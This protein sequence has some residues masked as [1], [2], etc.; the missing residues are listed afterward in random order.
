[1]DI[2]E[3]KKQFRTIN[4]CIENKQ[5][6]EAFKMLNPLLLELH[7]SDLIDEHYNLELTYKNTLKYLSQGIKDPNQYQILNHLTVGIL[8]LS[9][10]TQNQLL[11][12]Y[13]NE[14]GYDLKREMQVR[15]VTPLDEQLHQLVEA[16]NDAQLK[17]MI[18]PAN[19]YPDDFEKLTSRMFQYLWLSDVFDSN[20]LEAISKTFESSSIPWH[21]QSLM[22]S[23]LL[24]GLLRRWNTPLILCLFDLTNHPDARIRMRVMVNLIIVLSKY[25]NRLHLYPEI[26]NRLKLMQD[27]TAFINQL[28]TLFIQLIRTRETEKISQKLHDEIIPEVIKMQSVIREKL[29]LDNLI[30]DSSDDKNPE[31]TEILS[32]SPELLGKLEE[33]SKWQMEGADVFLNTFQMLKHFPFFNQFSNWFLPF[34]LD[35]PNMLAAMNDCG[36]SLKNSPIFEN[37]GHSGFLCNSDKYSLFL[38][39]PHM[40]AM[41]RDMM[42]QMFKAE[43]E[44]LGEIEKDELAVNPGKRELAISNQYI[45]D[46]YRFFKVHPLK[47]Q[48]DDIFDNEMNYTQSWFFKQLFQGNGPIRQI[49][50]YYFTK[51]YFADAI[52]VFSQ[53]KE[54][55]NNIEILQKT[56]YC[57]LK[58]NQY[59]KALEL[60][61]K[62]DLIKPD[63]K[64]TVKKIALCYI[65]LKNPQKALHYYLQAADK[66]PDNLQIQESIGH[67]YLETGNYEEALKYYFRIEYTDANNTR[68]WRPISWCSLVLGKFDQAE[69]YCNKL[70]LTGKNHQDFLNLGH[71]HLLRGQI[72]EALSCYRD[73]I[74]ATGSLEQF[75]THFNSD[76]SVLFDNGIAPDDIPL[77]TDQLRYSLEE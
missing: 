21:T 33:I 42:G 1:M 15:N 66:E 61:L 29:D 13:S 70:I 18:S 14:Y 47:K 2:K 43:I 37:V 32:D 40:P 69:K 68:V 34:Y 12:K 27:N 51:G 7:N 26:V 16:L 46:L 76:C 22:S 75:L 58:L 35:H 52:N 60:F 55:E 53:L 41:Q 49:G 19:A 50:E 5:I 8:Q 9:D 24:M 71:V 45:Q 23:A 54:E 3:I 4:H 10:N 36:E 17:A 48:F 73:S 11:T 77:L 62:S 57:H 63:N 74:R 38:S 20:D 64:W 6:K 28:Q 31:W 72:K 39:L 44:Q 56:G 59:N 67:C 25:D 65:K 30:T